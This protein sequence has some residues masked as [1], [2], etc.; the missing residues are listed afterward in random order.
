MATY[1][2][3]DKDTDPLA[4]D[5]IAAGST[6]QVNDGDTFV[7]MDSA[8]ANTKF[9]SADGTP[10]TFEILFTDTPTSG[11]DIDVKADLTADIGVSSGVDLSSVK[12][13]ASGSD[14]TTMVV[15][16]GATIGQFTGSGSGTDTLSIGS[17]VTASSS[18]SLGDGNNI[19]TIGD[20]N[21]FLGDFTTGDGADSFTAGDGN[22]FTNTVDLGD[23]A[24]DAQFGDNN[25]INVLWTGNDA[26]TAKVGLLDTTQSQVI[27]GVSHEGGDG[28][29]TN[30]DTVSLALSDADM[31]LLEAELLANGYVET[32]KV[33][34]AGSGADYH[35]H[36][37]N[38]EINDWENIRVVCFTP[39]TLIET[40]AGSR[41]V[42]TLAAGDAVLTSDNGPQILRWIGRK[43]VPARGRH[44][45]VSI[46]VGPL[47]NRRSLLLSPQHRILLS[48]AR[49]TPYFEVSEVLA[50]AMGLAGYAGIRRA[51]QE[52][53]DYIHL[54]FDRH[55]LLFANGLRA[56][57]LY[58]P[59]DHQLDEDAAS[60]IAALCPEVSAKGLHKAPA[61]PL[62]KPWE[63]ALSATLIGLDGMVTRAA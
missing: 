48:D 10:T 30:D 41:P 1:Y 18:I 50:P 59:A 54:L 56:E 39:G 7:F 61:R 36:V 57:S 37:N 63:V 20:N 17:G 46:P 40:P 31:A 28:D 3:V 35:V 45:P 14:G 9:E 53:V 44:A 8:N 32:G 21:T 60:E 24:D 62:L 43:R 55:E 42:E 5:E 19:I 12:I 26:D 52:A 2:I 11:Y 58:L 16:D 15:L 6:I 4:A 47:G 51:P 22:S 33:W 25:Y 29:P 38:L 13:D 27:D 34:S 49:L 23:G